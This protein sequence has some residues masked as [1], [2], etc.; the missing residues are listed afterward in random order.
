MENKEMEKALRESIDQLLTEAD[1]RKLR[2]IWTVAR[3]IVGAKGGT[4]CHASVRAGS[5]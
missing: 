1:V 4:D 5:Q 2:L 3:E